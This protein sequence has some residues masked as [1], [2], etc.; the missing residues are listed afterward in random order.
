MK[1]AADRKAVW[2]L[3][4][5]GWGLL[6]TD[7]DETSVF[8]VWPEK[9]YAEIYAVD[10]WSRYEASEIEL[11]DFLDELLPKLRGDGIEITVFP[12]SRAGGVIPTLGVLERDLRNEL[13]RIE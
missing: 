2:G 1:V 3:W 12:T 6:A 10:D 13:S 4:S 7:D 9:A 11:S 5:E 8:P